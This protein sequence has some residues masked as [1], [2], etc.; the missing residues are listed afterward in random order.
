M[1][2]LRGCA[3]GSSVHM[4]PP[5]ASQ[6]EAGVAAWSSHSSTEHLGGPEHQVKAAQGTASHS[7]REPG[8]LL[9]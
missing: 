4:S 3:A 7:L 1:S 2:K 6:L 5:P 9:C 8:A